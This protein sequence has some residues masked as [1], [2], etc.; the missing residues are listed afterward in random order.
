MISALNPAHIMIV[1]SASASASVGA[2]APETG[3]RI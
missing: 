1:A 2:A 3:L